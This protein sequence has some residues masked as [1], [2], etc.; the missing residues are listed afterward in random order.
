M[1]YTVLLIGFT[2]TGAGL[3]VLLVVGDVLAEQRSSINL[4][5]LKRYSEIGLK[6]LD[7]LNAAGQDLDEAGAQGIA[8]EMRRRIRILAKAKG[9]FGGEPPDQDLDSYLGVV[10]LLREAFIPKGIEEIEFPMRA[11]IRADAKTRRS[12][13]QLMIVLRS[14]RE[15]SKAGIR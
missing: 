7:V 3:L 8:E 14:L 1:T 9:E 13:L 12:V 4:A 5:S 15:G 10:R 6:E 11:Y 2:I